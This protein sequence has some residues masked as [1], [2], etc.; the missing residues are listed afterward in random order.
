MI[1]S[2]VQSHVRR[3]TSAF[4]FLPSSSPSPLSNT[5][6]SLSFS[7]LH[8]E[9]KRPQS[10]SSCSSHTP[11]S[12]L[13]TASCVPSTRTGEERRVDSAPTPPN[14]SDEKL[15][16]Q[17]KAPK[18][19]VVVSSTKHGR[20]PNPARGGTLRLQILASTSLH[21]ACAAQN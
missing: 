9:M 21:G 2:C 11:A 15:A 5:A 14:R 20:P 6:T 12:A 1:Q 10:T 4:S 7:L 13:L 3:Y 16:C 8:R 17:T 19:L 18:V